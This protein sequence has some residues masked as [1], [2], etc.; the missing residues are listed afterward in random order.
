M[1]TKTRQQLVNVMYEIIQ[2]EKLIVPR[3][4]L[5]RHPTQGNQRTGGTTIKSRRYN[6]N[7][8]I[9]ITISSPKYVPDENGRHFLRN[10]PSKKFRY[11]GWH[12]VSRERVLEIAAHEM[13][14]LR[15]WS[16]EAEHKSYTIHLLSLLSEKLKD[17]NVKTTSE[18]V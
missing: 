18:V 16:H 15:F 14:H 8:R 12:E 10:D 11:M 13:A 4:I 2:E 6:D 5:I 9:S 17:W 7:F 3:R 1:D